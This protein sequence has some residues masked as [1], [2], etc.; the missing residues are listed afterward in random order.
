MTPNLFPQAGTLLSISLSGMRHRALRAVTTVFGS[1]GVV[2]MLVALLSIAEGY[3]Q[4]MQTSTTDDSVLILMDGATAEISSSIPIDEVALIRQST[5]IA[6]GANDA[7]VL[8]AEP[9][10]TAKLP[11]REPGVEMNISLRGVEPAAYELTQIR[12]VS[13]RLPASGVR[14]VI[15]GKLARGRLSGVDPGKDIRI[16]NSMWRVVGEFSSENGAA[17]SEIWTDA[18]ALTASA[19]RGAAVQLI[20]L[21]LAPNVRFADFARSLDED[22]RL[23]VRAVSQK[24][25]LAEQS[26]TLQSFVRTL[27]YGISLL[28]GLGA[29][30]AALGTSYASVAVRIREIGTL[31]ALGFH[32]GSIFTSVIAESLLLTCVGGFIGAIAAYL[33][34]DGLQVSTVLHSSNYT[35]VAFSFLVSPWILVQA[36]LLAVGIGLAGSM[37]P[38]WKVLTISIAKASAERR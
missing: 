34:F 30:F 36:A 18:G 7:P 23:H 21:E 3:R 35:Q 22:P 17:E 28:M 33:I 10:T 19:D 32:D 8:S 12:L 24:D 4:I 15:V 27:G 14:E 6:R 25:Y 9:F 2:A 5:L 13:G 26:E 31:K 20:H 11:G 16:G 37:Y 29:A 38:A 1:I